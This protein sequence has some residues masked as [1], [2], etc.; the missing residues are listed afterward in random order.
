M[1]YSVGSAVIIDWIT[2][3]IALSL[4]L[5]STK[6]AWYT[7]EDTRISCILLLNSLE[8]ARESEAVMDEEDIFLDDVKIR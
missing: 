3:G 6:V 4:S 8:G 1:A 7:R 5:V 2:R